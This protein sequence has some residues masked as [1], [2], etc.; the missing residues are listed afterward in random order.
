MLNMKFGNAIDQSIMS[1][2]FGNII[3]LGNYNVSCM[4]LPIKLEIKSR[5]FLQKKLHNSFLKDE[6]AST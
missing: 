1:I 6:V 3:K 2:K 4:L 5:N